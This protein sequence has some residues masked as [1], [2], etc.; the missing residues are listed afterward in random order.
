M[1]EAT[2]ND[3]DPI[4]NEM[5]WKLFIVMMIGNFNAVLDIQIIS[6]S[7]NEISGGLS[8]GQDEIVWVQ[9]IYLIGEVIGIAIAASFSKLLSTRK[10][11]SLCCIVFALS[12]LGCGMAWDIPSLLTFRA[13]QG[14]SG[15]GMIPTAMASMFLLFP[16][17]KISIPLVIVG[18]VNTSASTI[19]PF[20][21]GEITNALSWRWLFYINLFPCLFIIISLMKLPDLD[22]PDY[23]LFSKIDWVGALFMSFTLGSF[24]YLMDEGPRNNW[25]DDENVYIAIIILG[26]SLV[27]FVSRCFTFTTPI[28]EFSPFKDR[29][30]TISVIIAFF[31]GVSLYGLIYITPVFLGVVRGL[32]SQQIGVIMLVN[33]AAMFV[34][35]LLYGP[36]LS[37]IEPRINIFAGLIMVALGMYTNANF[38]LQTDFHELLIP[39]ILRGFGLLICMIS[40]SKVAMNTM[41]RELIKGASGIINLTRNIGGAVGLAFFNTSLAYSTDMH[42][43]SI[44]DN[45]SW[46]SYNAFLLST[47]NESGTGFVPDVNKLAALKHTVTN[48]AFSNAINDLLIVLT[49]VLVAISLLVM[50]IVKNEDST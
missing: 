7:I 46:G 38:T 20:V 33:G 30:F 24:V 40:I 1:L 50:F 39:Q 41:P 19:G 14:V 9:T 6:S 47:D 44:A 8:A 28:I 15:G 32:N 25:F 49:F 16:G 5:A 13:V 42:L 27:G 3:P 12:S 29:N 31:I 48:I 43:H 45:M 2:T 37:K 4:T 21:G 18:L 36:Y 11:F 34:A 10:Y 17:K 22:K 35:A 23:T 26:I